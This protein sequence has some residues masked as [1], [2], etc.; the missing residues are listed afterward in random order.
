MA[1]RNGTV[2][3]RQGAQGSQGGGRNQP[4]QTYRIG[5]IQGTIWKNQSD[6]GDWFSVSITRS[7]K[8]NSKPP[9]W[10]Q[11]TTFGKDDLLTVAEVTRMCFHFIVRQGASGAEEGHVGDDGGA[12]GDEFGAGIPF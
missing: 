8:D 11:A 10:K 5:R 6:K 1:T 3:G 9:Q 12:G 7:Y 4:A 2:Q